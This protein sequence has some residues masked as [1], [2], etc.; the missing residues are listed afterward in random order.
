MKI[1]SWAFIFLLFFC[2]KSTAQADELKPKFLKKEYRGFTLWLDCKTHNGAIAFHYKIG[3]DKNN[4]RNKNISYDFDRKVSV[5]CQPQTWR[6][7]RTN[8]VDPLQGEWRRGTLVPSNHMDSSLAKIKETYYLTN[9]LPQNAIL[10]RSIGAWYY[11]EMITECYRDLSP[12]EVWG[13]VIWGDDPDND[14]FTVTHGIKTP[15][16]WWK[17]IYRTDKKTYL[18]WIFPNHWSAKASEMDRFLVSIETLENTVE[19]MPDIGTLRTS[20]QAKLPP[21]KTWPLVISEDKLE[22]EGKET[23][24]D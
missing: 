22:C 4:I 2:F 23:S 10:S 16:F 1:F 14:F 17:L 5:S 20:A 15:D 7:Y 21:T 11:S 18:A 19:F 12:L 24:S 6:S 13:G 9:T 8:T 3:K